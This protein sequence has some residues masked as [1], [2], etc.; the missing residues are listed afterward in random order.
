MSRCLSAPDAPKARCLPFLLDLIPG[1]ENYH[2]RKNLSSRTPVYLILSHALI[3]GGEFVRGV[4][5]N[6]GFFLDLQEDLRGV[7]LREVIDMQI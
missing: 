7:G 2:L 1:N 5:R 4:W 3:C 6:T